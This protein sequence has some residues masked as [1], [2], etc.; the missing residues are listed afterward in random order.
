M[1]E[2][3][4]VEKIRAPQY[5]YARDRYKR[6][7]VYHS[8]SPA[9]KKYQ[10]HKDGT[11]VHPKKEAIKKRKKERSRKEQKGKKRKE[12]K[13]MLSGRRPS[14]DGTRLAVCWYGRS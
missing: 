13:Y 12:R 2:N 14:P 5:Q 10:E 3:N 11:Y 7:V 6:A 8:V 1:E 9:T 4:K